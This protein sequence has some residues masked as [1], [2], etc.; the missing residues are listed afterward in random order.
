MGERAFLSFRLPIRD[1]DRVKALAAKRGESVQDLLGRLIETLLKEEERHSP[2]LSDVLTGLRQHKR[3]LQ[4]RGVARL[5]VFGSV[6]RGEA[7]P[8]SD[9]DL[10]A[11]FDLEAKVSLTGFV[12]L[13]QDLSEMLGTPV[14]LAEWRT[15]RPHV[16]D[17]AEHDAVV[18]F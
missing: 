3:D 7:H 9:V 13:R 5:W 11:E 6:V 10:L 12:R 18:V 14:D 15:L 4:Q 8:D 16:R 17:A 1:R 2:S